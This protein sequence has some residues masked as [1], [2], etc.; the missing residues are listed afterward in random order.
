[1]G[2]CDSDFVKVLLKEILTRSKRYNPKLI[3]VINKDKS[4]IYDNL[5]HIL[6]VKQKTIDKHVLISFINVEKNSSKKLLRHSL[7]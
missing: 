7:I 6:R 2:E 4:Q 3:F 1:M 5:T